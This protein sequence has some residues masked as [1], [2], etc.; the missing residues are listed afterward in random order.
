MQ[1]PNRMECSGVARTPM[2]CLYCLAVAGQ[3]DTNG[4]LRPRMPST[5]RANGAVCGVC[6]VQLGHLCTL[7]PS[8]AS[9]RSGDPIQRCRTCVVTWNLKTPPWLTWQ[10]SWIVKCTVRVPS[11]KYGCRILYR[12]VSI[13]RPRLMVCKLVV[14]M[15]LRT[16]VRMLVRFLNMF[17]LEW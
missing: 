7:L 17:V 13:Y 14:F 6:C 4:E 3:S 5:Q 12:D 1:L 11:C 8:S 10:L 16:L 15:Q 2:Y 9:G